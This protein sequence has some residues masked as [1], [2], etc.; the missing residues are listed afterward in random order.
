MTATAHR[1]AKSIRDYLTAHRFNRF[2]K[3]DLAIGVG[4]TRTNRSFIAGLR[5]L[6]DSGEVNVEGEGKTRW[7]S[8]APTP[9]PAYGPQGGGGRVLQNA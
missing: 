7:V 8:L 3:T 9:K 2:N 1:Y 6:V 4:T 5:S